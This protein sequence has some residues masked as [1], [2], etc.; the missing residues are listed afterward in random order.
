MTNSTSIKERILA[1]IAQK[2]IRNAE[3]ERRAGLSNGYINNL[4][5]SPGMGKL[6]N[7]LTAFPEIN[8]S[9]LLMGEGE[10]LASAGGS[11]TGGYGAPSKD[12]EIVREALQALSLSNKILAEQ[13][14]RGSSQN[15]QLLQLVKDIYYEKI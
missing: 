12:E 1:F 7:I 6:D 8:R 14:E 5:K 13:L 2:G 3:F 15:E 4:K 10:M 9:W 11:G